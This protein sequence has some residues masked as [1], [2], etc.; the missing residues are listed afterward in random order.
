MEITGAGERS[1]TTD[2]DGEY[3]VRLEAGDYTLTVSQ[4]GFVTETRD[5]TVVADE[6]LTEDFSLAAAT[7]T[8]LSG[9]VTDG[10]GHDWPLYAKVAIE[11]PGP[12]VYT[13]PETGAYSVQV[14]DDGTYSISVTAEY[15]GY[16]VTTEDVAV[17][18]PTTHD[19]AVLVDG[20]TCTAPGY[21][22]NTAGTTTEGFD[23]GALPAGWTIVDNKGNG[24]VWRFDDPKARGNLTGGT[25]QVRDHGQRLLRQHGRPG[26]LP[27]H[28]EHRHDGADLT[29]GGLQAGL[30]QPG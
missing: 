18:G 6:T 14:P 17:D 28:A 9:T 1:L 10:S 12:D 5:V 8:T 15:P 23:G 3:S 21:V 25:G 30:P 26:H 11:G 22:F 24:Q 19:V 2:A 16:D 7:M 29:G 13:D 27:G 4:Y 20:S